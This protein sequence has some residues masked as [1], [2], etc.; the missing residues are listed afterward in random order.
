MNKMQ[1]RKLRRLNCPGMRKACQILINACLS[2]LQVKDPS[3][4]KFPLKLLESSELNEVVQIDHQKICMTDTGYNQILVIID[5]PPC[6]R[7]VPFVPCRTGS[8][9]YSYLPLGTLSLFPC[10]D[11]SEEIA[12]QFVVFLYPNQVPKPVPRLH[13]LFQCHNFSCHLPRVVDVI[14]VFDAIGVLLPRIRGTKDFISCLHERV[15]QETA[16][17]EWSVWC[18]TAQAQLKQRKKYDK[19]I[20]EARYQKRWHSMYDCLRMSSRQRGQKNGEDPLW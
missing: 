14:L 11:P 4:M 2:C 6:D 17:I 10:S 16:R 8:R 12:S 13:M 1:Q 5:Y 9:F 7:V 20:L 18:K 19:M 15:K 3:K